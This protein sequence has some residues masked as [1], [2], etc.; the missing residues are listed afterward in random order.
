MQSMMLLLIRK[1]LCQQWENSSYPD[2][3]KDEWA[4]DLLFA[5]CNIR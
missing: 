3:D 5:V 4:F 2:I 1:I